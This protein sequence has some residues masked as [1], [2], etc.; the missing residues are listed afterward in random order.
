M[1]TGS[2]VFFSNIDTE[3]PINNFS[4]AIFQEILNTGEENI[5]FSPLS[6]Y[7]ALAMATSGA[8]YQTLYELE[9]VLGISQNEIG[10]A[11]NQLYREL[12]GN[13]DN[14]IL[15]IVNSVWISDKFDI[16]PQLEEDMQNYF[17][18]LPKIRDFT[19]P[20]VVDEVNKW[21]NEA[22]QGLIEEMLDEIDEE[23]VAMLINAIYLK[24]SWT[25]LLQKT[26]QYTSFT[27]ENGTIVNN[28][29]FITMSSGSSYL[30]VSVS[31]DYEA[32]MIPL[33]YS[34]LGFFVIRP[35]NSSINQF[36]QNNDI[37]QIFRDLE[38]EMA[39]IFMPEFDKSFDIELTCVLQNM[40]LISAF[41]ELSA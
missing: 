25:F 3:A 40:G 33:A 39:Q 36:V 18:S 4:W 6:V 14:F 16:I 1:N 21:I 5:V 35:T 32:F 20:R 37:E 7:Y 12:T 22:T 13:G 15:D 38:R 8:S 30:P 28:V 23:T 9:T 2:K 11:L 26:N 34:N 29:S 19:S 31:S 27:L 17:G 24:A 41:D 10:A